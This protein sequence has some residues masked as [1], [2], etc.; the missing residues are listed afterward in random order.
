MDRKPKVVI[1]VLNYNGE[2]CLHQTL[3]SLI[4][5]EYTEK[6]IVVV[7][8][9]SIDT[10]FAKAKEKF[11]TLQFVELPFNGGFA[12]GMN[13][14]IEW[15]LKNE[16]DFVWLFNYDALAKPD[17]LTILVDEYLS[18]Q[19]K[20]ILS[21]RIVNEKNEVWFEGGQ[22]NFWKMRVEHLK[23]KCGVQTMQK[24]SFLTGCAL[25][26]PKIAIKEVGLLDETFFLYYEDADYSMRA[27]KQGFSLYVASKACVVHSEESVHNP[28]KTYY[29]VFSGLLFFQ[30]YAKGFFSFYQAIYVI[31]RR[32]KNWFDIKT[33]TAVAKEVCLAYREFYAKN[34]PSFLHRLRKLQ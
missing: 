24:T 15:A 31:L 34:P 8:N 6:E 2:K 26:I 13:K 12:Y 20:S 1:I 5:L 16:A 33:G 23:Q 22:I 10:S 3:L 27:R 18:L 14:G 21:P 19:E 9:H 29:L 30:K 25:F 11:P 7:D 4:E 28:K 32:L 17:S